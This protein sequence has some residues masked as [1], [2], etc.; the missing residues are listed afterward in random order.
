MRFAAEKGYVLPP[1]SLN[2][3]LPFC[4]NCAF[5]ARQ[6]GLAPPGALVSQ[7]PGKT[8]IP[9]ENLTDADLARMVRLKPIYRAAE[10]VNW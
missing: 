4:P 5:Q 6:A 3:S 10:K 1:G 2:P 8:A 9:L 7:G